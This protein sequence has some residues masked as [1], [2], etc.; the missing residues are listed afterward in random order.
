M[1]KKDLIAIVTDM[2]EQLVREHNIPEPMARGLVGFALIKNK[3]ALVDAIK[4]PKLD[5]VQ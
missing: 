3:A 5:Q 2:V 1:D 4:S